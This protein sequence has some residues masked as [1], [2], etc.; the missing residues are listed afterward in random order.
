M[1][2]SLKKHKMGFT[3]KSKSKFNL[4]TALLNQLVI[5]EK[6][7]NLPKTYGLFIILIPFLCTSKFYLKL[8]HP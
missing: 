4:T 8:K 3:G 7:V 5:K 1:R 6:N 2:S